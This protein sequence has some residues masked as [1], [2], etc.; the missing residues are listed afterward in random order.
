MSIAQT[1]LVKRAHKGHVPLLVAQAF[2]QVHNGV[3]VGRNNIRHL[4]TRAQTR[5]IGRGFKGRSAVEGAYREEIG[6]HGTG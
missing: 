6:W 1:I 5:L 4:D 2:A 3:F